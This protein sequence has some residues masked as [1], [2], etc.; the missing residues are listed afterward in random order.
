MDIFDAQFENHSEETHICDSRRE[1][2][3]IIFTCK[4]CPD[5]E[6]RYNYKTREMKVKNSSPHINHVGHFVPKYLQNIN[7]N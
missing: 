3:W 1:G 5:Y 6:R 2:D 4:Y 7:S